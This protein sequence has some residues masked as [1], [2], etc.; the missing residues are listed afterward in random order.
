MGI[1]ESVD[2]GE[3]NVLSFFLLDFCHIEVGL[4]KI[5]RGLELRAFL[6]V[7]AA[8]GAAL[9]GCEVTGS[10]SGEPAGGHIG[11]LGGRDEV[12]HL[13]ADGGADL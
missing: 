10:L 13:L 7:D 1:L 9:R 3:V 4:A 6:K 8:E 2:L 11:Y 5:L 12:V